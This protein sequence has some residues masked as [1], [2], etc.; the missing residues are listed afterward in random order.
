MINTSSS[1]LSLKSLVDDLNR[2]MTMSYCFA[3]AQLNPVSKAVASSSALQLA[4]VINEY[5]VLPRVIVELLTA[6]RDSA[7]SASLIPVAEELTRN[8]G[9]EQ[10]SDTDGV[11][12]YD[13]LKAGIVK[14]LHLEV[15][16]AV[17]PKTKLFVHS[18]KQIAFSRNTAEAIGAAYALESSARPE[19]LIVR[20]LFQQFARSKNITLNPEGGLADFFD[21]H[22]NVWEVGHECKLREATE[23]SIT[24]ACHQD[25]ERGFIGVMELMEQWWADMAV[26]CKEA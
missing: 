2:R 19:L 24:P 6:V 7:E 12:H 15:S 11:A 4:S 20:E 8:L 25:F 16:E 1:P 5:A 17:S 10:G 14:E 22:I 3:N 9:E 18:I 13:L 23:K 26:E 21:R